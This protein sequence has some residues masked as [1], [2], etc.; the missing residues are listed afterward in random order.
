MEFG[1]EKIFL[2]LDGE[3]EDVFVEEV[4]D[5]I[6]NC[7]KEQ[8]DAWL[9]DAQE[10]RVSGG[11]IKKLGEMISRLTLKRGNGNATRI[12]P[13]F[14][15]NASGYDAMVAQRGAAERAAGQ[16]VA[17]RKAGLQSAAEQAELNRLREL[18]LESRDADEHFLPTDHLMEEE[19]AP[20]STRSS[21]ST[22]SGTP[23]PPARRR[24]RSC[25]RPSTSRR[26]TSSLRQSQRCTA[27]AGPPA[28]QS[29]SDRRG[30]TWS[31]STRATRCRT[32]CIAST[33]GPGTSATTS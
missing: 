30:S 20:R 33:L 17:D 15:G 23:R 11:G 25:S 12:Q 6:A 24:F 3:T 1:A 32:Q 9:L 28:S 4:Q 31:R 2:E 27:P 29:S 26:P 7:A 22:Q 21:C 5:G 16:A 14:A 10:N 18:G 13:R 19:V 8:A